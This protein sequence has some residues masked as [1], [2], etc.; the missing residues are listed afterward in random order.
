MTCLSQNDF[1]ERLRRFEIVKCLLN[2]WLDLVL[3][4]L[5][6]VSGMVD[7]FG[8]KGLASQYFYRVALSV[9]PVFHILHVF[10]P[11]DDSVQ[12]ERNGV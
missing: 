11:H 5:T 8:E 4:N 1:D 12:I 3:H 6:H 7:H 2:I 10:T 9:A